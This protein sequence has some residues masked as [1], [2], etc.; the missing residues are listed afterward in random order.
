[1]IFPLFMLFV[2][3]LFLATVRWEEKGMFL[4]SFLILCFFECRSFVRSFVRSFNV[5]S[6][7][8]RFVR[9]SCHLCICYLFFQDTRSVFQ[10]LQVQDPA[11]QT[12]LAV[13]IL[14]YSLDMK[15]NFEIRLFFYWRD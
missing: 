8:F 14:V 2:F 13:Y 5:L 9:A 7:L 12:G 11:Q 6:D 4:L 3:P 15:S 10:S 1:M